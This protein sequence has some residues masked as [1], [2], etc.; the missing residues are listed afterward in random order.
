MHLY[1]W[2]IEALNRLDNYENMTFEEYKYSF[3]IIKPNGA[4]HIEVYLEQ[5]KC[6]G[7]DILGIFAIHNHEEVNLAL[8][9][10][11]R[12]RSHIL[13]INKM[14]KDFYCDNA[15]LIF[16]GEKNITYDDFV[17]KVHQY[18]WKARSLV[19]KKYISYVFDTT[20]ILGVN[21]GQRL[22]VIDERGREVKKYDMNDI[23]SF[24]VALPNSLHS[25]DASVVDTINELRIISKLELMRKE[26]IIS[27]E[28][29]QRIIYYGTMEMLKDM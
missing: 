16:L 6:M 26:N 22:K 28:M 8:H 17:S 14:F 2:L 7:I 29:L 13:P 15:I 3:I 19:E 23:G 21:K 27:E 18:K 20:S 24:M 12:E 4:K 11:E 25:P 5:L 10:T 1:T 9:L